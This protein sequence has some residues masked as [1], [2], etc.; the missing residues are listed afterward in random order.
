[1]GVHAA[2]RHR[3]E[4]TK[5]RRIVVLMTEKEISQIDEW[6]P[7]AGMPSRTAAI[8]HLMQKGLEATSNARPSS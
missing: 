3:Y 5:L 8:R 6:G 1:M 7:S 2:S 4:R